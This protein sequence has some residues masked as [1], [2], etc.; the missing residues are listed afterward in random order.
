MS[1]DKYIRVKGARVNN[2]KNI[3]VTIPRNTLTVLTGV[4]GSAIAIMFGIYSQMV[5]SVSNIIKELSTLRW[6]ALLL[7]GC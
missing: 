4:S 3:D 2:L 5:D 1:E 6:I 7:L